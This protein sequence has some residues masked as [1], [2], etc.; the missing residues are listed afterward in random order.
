MHHDNGVSLAG[1]H[2][3]NAGGRSSRGCYANGRLSNGNGVCGGGGYDDDTFAWDDEELD[4]GAMIGDDSMLTAGDEVDD[5]DENT[6]DSAVD[7]RLG[8]S[9]MYDMSAIPWDMMSKWCR[10]TALANLL[11]LW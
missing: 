1:C 10:Y 4:G 2:H 5:E 8:E 3:G 11:T 6:V 9:M 7:S